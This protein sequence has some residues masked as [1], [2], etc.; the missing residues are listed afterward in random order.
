MELLSFFFEIGCFLKQVL[1]QVS[2][3]DHHEREGGQERA[4]NLRHDFCKK[5]R[6]GEKGKKRGKE[7][8]KKQTKKGKKKLR[9][10]HR[11]FL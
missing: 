8:N 4:T 3:Q 7:T 11:L 9:S 5:K 2:R 6:K 10:H 1:I